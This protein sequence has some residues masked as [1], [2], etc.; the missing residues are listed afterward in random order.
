MMKLWVS[1]LRRIQIEIASTIDYIA[2]KLT[3]IPVMRYS[4][5]TPN[6]FLGGQYGMKA[7]ETFRINGITA[8]VNMRLHSIHTGTKV[9]P[10]VT[11]LHLPTVDWTPPSIENLKKGV[12]FIDEEIKGGGRVYIH[13]KYGKGRGPSMVI[14]YLISTGMVYKDALELV[15]KV[16]PFAQPNRVQEQQLL[17]FEKL[18]EREKEQEKK[19]KKA[20][21]TVHT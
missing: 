4:K 12:A 15:Q 6:L 14:A 7:A 10:D 11:V 9:F 8:I 2:R 3:G 13:C 20:L 21:G 19:E 16:R 18:L 5:I 1:A 17:E